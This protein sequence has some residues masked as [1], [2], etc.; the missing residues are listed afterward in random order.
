MPI[1]NRIPLRRISQSEFGEMA[2]QV[3]SHV[4]AIHNE[5]GRFFHEG[6]YKREVAH[7]MSGVRLE[8]PVDVTFDSF[9]KTYF[10]DLLVE[11]SAVFEFKAVERLARRHRAQL[12]NYL[13]LCDVSHG[14]LVNIRTEDV[15]HEFV[16]THWQREDRL[17]FE[18]C[19]QRWKATVGPRQLPEVLIPLLRD[20]GTGL[21]ISLY[22]E[23][24]LHF[25]GGVA[26]VD[27]RVDVAIGGRLI[28]EQTMRFIAPDIA[29][30]ITAFEQRLEHFETHARR[31]LAHTKLRAVA[32]VNIGLREVTFTTLEA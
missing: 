3:M 23:A 19:L 11:D 15:E 20:L 13:L 6:I 29:L 14:K 16:N 26:E 5:I 9:R 31:L 18:V 25:F 32:W 28:G 27:R 17:R 1:F 22:E 2:Y 24:V 4:F 21:E 12:L 10:L 7:R 8:E 30:K